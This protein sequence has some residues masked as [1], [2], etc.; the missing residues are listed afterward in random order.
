MLKGEL[1]SFSLPEIFQ[2]LAINNHTG[3]LKIWWGKQPPKLLYFDRG[4]IRLFSDG[5]AE[6]PKLGSVLVRNGVLTSQDLADAL[7]EQERTK[8]ILGEVLVRLNLATSQDIAKALETQ[9]REEIYDLFLWKQGS[10][11]FHMGYFPEE[12]RESVQNKAGIALNTNSVIMEGLRRLDEWGLVKKR[13]ATFDEIFIRED[14]SSEGI[15]PPLRAFYA[16]LDGTRPVK[17]LMKSFPG[18]RFDCCKF[19]CDLADGGR[20]RVLTH[21][22]LMQAATRS[23]Q[24]RQYAQAAVFLQFATQVKPSDPLTLCELG[25][26]YTAFHQDSAA[27]EAYL[28]AF[29]IFFEQ[30]DFSQAVDMGEKVLAAGQ[31]GEEDLEK[32]FSTYL[33]LKSVKKAA[34]TGN[35]LVTLLQ[36]RGAIDK[37]ASV[38][39]TLANLDPSD[40]NLKIQVATLFEKAGDKKRATEYLQQVTAALESQKK[41][42]EAIKILRLMAEINPDQPELKTRIQDLH[43]LVERIEKRKKQRARV[44]TVA[45][46][47]F[48]VLVVVPA[49]YEI[50]AREYFSHAQRLEQIS[51]MS[52]DFKKAKDAYERI[53]K[54]YGFSSKVAAAQQ[55]LD[56]IS[57]LERNFVERLDEETAKRKEQYEAK[58]ARLREGLVSVLAE[59][60]QAEAAGDFKKAFEICRRVSIE[61]SE[62]PAARKLLLPLRI[63]SVPSGATVTVNGAEVGKTPLTYRYKPRTT[64][65]LSITK[66]SCETVRKSFTPEE[67]WEIH[68]ELRRRPMG[69]ITPAPTLQQP[70]VAALGKVTFA[71]RDGILYSMDPL[72]KI[73]VWPRVVGRFG[74]RVSNLTSHRDEIYVGNVIGEVTAISAHTGK[75]RWV[76]KVGSPVLAAPGISRDSKWLAVGTTSGSVLILNN[77]TGSI[78]SRFATENEV[79][80]RPVFSGEML[81]AGSTDNHLYGFSLA[82]KTVAF[83]IELG[84]DITLD[85]IEGVEGVFASSQDGSVHHLDVANRQ[86]KWSRSL[87]PAKVTCMALGPFGLC[88]GTSAGKLLTLDP[89]TGQT[90][91][92]VQSGNSPVSGVAIHKSQIYIALENGKVTALD[93]PTRRITWQY[94]SDNSIVIPPLAIQS[95][96]YVGGVTGKIEFIEVSE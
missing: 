31:L 30:G 24:G 52:M 50:K 43:L 10:F 44:F 86:L 74:D 61:Y 20:V 80:A 94:Q 88:A 56:R 46:F 3:T 39:G 93:G 77:E 84:D 58:V 91:W 37:A 32:L 1:A 54:T 48:L 62:V 96:L 16:S 7:G 57:D 25:K 72:K 5:S 4:E 36:R 53:L 47:L 83:A 29:R 13:V 2:S 95:V 67:Q 65:N 92:E 26:V 11:E 85:L 15:D 17:E 38:L 75:S 18:T 12:M 70:M 33:Q 40:L 82:K 73:I 14:D 35:Q 90:A 27:S 51:M 87:A 79:L 63:T 23:V 68:F 89:R 9:I 66:K 76:A 42:R 60:E 6:V 21:E 34:S 8:E 28:R 41:H 64:L 19:L 69:S 78:V 55:A 45:L 81:V 71:S 59:A 22:E 49:L